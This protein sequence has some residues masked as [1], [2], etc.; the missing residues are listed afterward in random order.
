MKR[1]YPDAEE[2]VPTNAPAPRGKPVQINAFVDVDHA[3]NLATI[4]SHSGILIFLNMAPIS[5]YSKR[6][7]SVETS[8]FLSEFVA[9]KITTE[10]IISLYY[11]LRMM[12][13]PLD[14]LAN[15]FCDNEAVYKNAIFTDST[16]KKKHNSVAYD[17]VR[18]SVAAEILVVIKED[19]GSNLADILI[20]SLP[21]DKRKYLQER[22]MID[23]KV[24]LLITNVI[25]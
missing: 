9:L 25:S 20:K 18:E 15:V 4:R 8:T 6:Q 24:S 23:E 2:R 11:K 14:G 10:L 16:L 12:G 17:K 5:W 13:I 1:F 7:N 3:G 21:L 22:I 19:S